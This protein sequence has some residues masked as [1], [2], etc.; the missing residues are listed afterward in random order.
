MKPRSHHFQAKYLLVQMALQSTAR[1]F[2]RFALGGDPLYPPHLW[3]ALGL[4]LERADRIP[5]EG[6]AMWR[7]PAH[8]G[9]AET[10]VLLARM[11]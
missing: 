8:A 6:I 4:D 2:A 5:N 7:Q 11:F 9:V 3:R 10:L 1:F